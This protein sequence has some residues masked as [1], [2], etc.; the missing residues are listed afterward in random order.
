MDIVVC[1]AEAP[2]SGGSAPFRL[3]RDIELDIVM[4]IVAARLAAPPSDG[5][6]PVERVVTHVP[7]L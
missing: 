6:A 2:P 1:L 4:D 7:A 5:C 3:A